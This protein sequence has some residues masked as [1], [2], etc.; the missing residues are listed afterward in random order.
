MGTM[1]VSKSERFFKNAK[2]FDPTRWLK[3]D[4]KSVDDSH[5]YAHLPFGFGAR[6]CI[7]RRI[8]EQEIYTLMAKLIQRYEVEYVGEKFG[9]RTKLVASP[10]KPLN[11]KFTKRS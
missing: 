6:Q 5:P 10:D 3:S 4:A 9:Y 11:L 8:A 7:G 2:D 1:H